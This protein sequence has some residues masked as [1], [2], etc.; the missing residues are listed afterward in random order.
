[1][2]AHHPITGKEIR[3]IQTDASIWKEQKTLVF[4][5]HP[6]VWDTVNTDAL[7]NGSAPSYYLVTKGEL[8]S[9]LCSKA[10]LIVTS[11]RIPVPTLTN[12]LCLEEFDKLYPHL[13][14]AWDGTEEDAV[15]LLAGLLRYPYVSGVKGW[16]AERLGI[17]CRVEKPYRL[18]WITQYYK[19]DSILRAQ[20]LQTCLQKNC[21]SQLIERVVLLNEKKEDV[22]SRIDQRVIGKRITYSDVMEAILGMPD[23]VLVAFANADICIDDATWPSL[24]SVN[25]E[26]KFLA[27]LR[28]DIDKKGEPVLFGPRAD[29]QDTWVVR[30]VDIKKRGRA[31]LEGLDI[32]FGYMGCDNVVALEMLKK[33]FLVVNP[34][35]SLKTWHYHASGVRSYD[36]NNVITRPVFHYI[37]PSGFHDLNPIIKLKAHVQS[38]EYTL[39]L[40]VRGRGAKNWLYTVNKKLN[41]SVMSW[42]LESLNSVKLVGPPILTLTNCFQT[43]QGLVYDKSSMYIGPAVKAQ[44]VWSSAEVHGMIPTLECKRGLIVPWPPGAETSREIYILQY[45]SRILQLR[46]ASGW[47]DGE[48]FC[49]EST[50]VVEA[51]NMFRWGV[52]K[53]PVIKYETDMQVWCHA[54]YAHT[55]TESD[56]A[57]PDDVAAL[58]S[59]IQWS[60]SVLSNF[61][62]SSMRIVIVEDGTVL[63]Q[64]FLR[65][66]EDVL[67]RAFDVQIVYP[68]RTSA[69]RM[70]D[71]LR[72]AWGIICS[73]GG[74]AVCGWNWLL[75]TGAY[76]FE[77]NSDNDVAIKLSASC[78]LEHRFVTKDTILE[79]VFAE[80]EVFTAASRPSVPV[81]HIP[82]GCV[83]G[84]FSH[85]GN[86]F[87]EMV[88][89]WGKNGYVRVKEDS[90]ATMVWWGNVGANGV[91]L[92]DRPT[93]D[94]KE[95][96]PLTEKAWAHTLG[97]KTPWTF[98]PQNPE[99]V[100]EMAL[101]PRS[102]DERKGVVFHGRA[103]TNTQQRRRPVV[104]EDACDTWSLSFTE[105]APLTPY[106]YL[107]ALRAARFGLCLPGASTRCT[108]EIECFAMGCVAIITPGVD[109]SGYINRPV[110]GVHYI[111]AEDP[112]SARAAA[113]AM[114]QEAWSAMS[115]AGHTWWKENASCE[116]SF[117]L[118]KKAIDSMK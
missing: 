81:I 68:G 17:Q 82:R 37:H 100:E 2:L 29:S 9:D 40:P 107:E 20:E 30:A 88:K 52:A 84:Y 92:Y 75:P 114:S 7:S 101:V 36:K 28:Y 58:R 25:M 87:R 64:E 33:K 42:N 71:V 117:N 72:G 43:Y 13:G 85:D 74:L 60:P 62:L 96:A 66:A 63:T 70:R 1:M 48:F 67:E 32:E 97:G 12:V 78:G 4:S 79:G 57:T 99:L 47:M 90:A 105:E 26:D 14:P 111:R 15:L 10:K 49:A 116:G 19:S 35:Y 77:V 113:L 55:V 98:W 59:A 41:D 24:W 112:T 115:A 65:A 51:L 83:E 102:W 31:A 44:K 50:T 106:L 45:I 8:R 61:R 93:D 104:W 34:A 22:D 118:T 39:N 69:D 91:L 54:A 46:S 110:E 109:M 3:V 23:D 95:A 21:D 38:V 5:K 108:R 53:M 11:R 6:S 86:E 89:L 94:W 16:R 73:G 80:E 18:W 76:V 56:C 103:S 27:L